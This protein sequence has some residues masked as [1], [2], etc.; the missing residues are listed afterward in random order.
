MAGERGEE[1]CRSRPPYLYSSVSVGT[2]PGVIVSR[3][4]S[5]FTWTRKRRKGCQNH[6]LEP[7]SPAPSGI[8]HCSQC[9]TRGSRAAGDA[10]YLRVMDVEEKVHPFAR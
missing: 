1:E 9:L 6:C 5:H 4:A 8:H 10:S 3:F 7:D 2:G